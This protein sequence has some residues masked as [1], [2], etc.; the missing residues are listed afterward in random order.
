MLRVIEGL[1][2]H[3]CHCNTLDLPRYNNLKQLVQVKNYRQFKENM[4]RCDLFASTR[5]KCVFV[6]SVYPSVQSYV[7]LCLVNLSLSCWTWV[8]CVD[9]MSLAPRTCQKS[10]T[11]LRRTAFKSRAARVGFMT[12]SVS[13]GQAFL[14]AP[15]FSPLCHRSSFPL[16]SFICHKEDEEWPPYKSQVQLF[17]VPQ[18]KPGGRRFDSWWCHWNFSLT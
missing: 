5:L 12:N 14:R 6:Y 1:K 9:F 7:K 13:R 17:K 18:Y 3:I 11:T 2:I 4:L 8:R 15:W 16:F 10:S